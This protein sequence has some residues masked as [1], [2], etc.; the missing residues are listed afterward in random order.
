[1][2]RL[3]TLTIAAITTSA[4][5]L[6]AGCGGNSSSSAS[7]PGSVLELM[8]QNVAE[9]VRKVTNKTDEA[10]S[11]TATIT[12]T[13]NG[14]P[15]DT[16]MVLH[17]GTPMRMELTTVYDGQRLS[18]RYI[19]STVYMELSDSRRASMGGKRW[20]KMDVSGA[21][22][23]NSFDHFES[24]DP[25]TQARMLLDQ[26]DVTV[27]GQET[28]DGVPT[29]HYSVTLSPADY[30]R[31][32]DEKSRS[33]VQQLLATEG[34][35]DINVHLWVDEEYRPRRVRTVYGT[36][37]LT[38]TYSDYGSAPEVVEPPASEVADFDL[39]DTPPIPEI[40]IPRRN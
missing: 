11:V 7:G 32:I 25:R 12:G 6:T 39:I 40:T 35:N 31:H 28:I 9:T 20:L 15:A 3:T 17:Y 33:V 21:M 1:M 19:G 10:T 8:A 38:V 29:V 27:V 4:L 16:R 5:V 36:T 23:Q 24:L 30:T 13:A 18:M 22:Q 26:G 34:I 2:R 37:D 14:V